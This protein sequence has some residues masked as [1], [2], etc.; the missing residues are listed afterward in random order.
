K[1]HA[2]KSTSR[3][4]GAESLGAL[5]EKLELAGKAGNEA[6]LDAELEGLLERCRALGAALSPLYA[7]EKEQHSGE[8]LPLISEDELREAYNSIREFASSLD[9]DSM[10]YALEYLDGFRIPESERERVEQI[11]RAAGSFDWD[12]VSALCK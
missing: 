4:V 7:S 6:A 12:S 8:D 5:A 9:A 10:T 3:A 2:L 1:V 11:R